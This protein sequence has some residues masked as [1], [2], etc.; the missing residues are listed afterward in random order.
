MTHYSH[1][2]INGEEDW[3]EPN[4]PRFMRIRCKGIGDHMYSPSPL[5]LRSGRHSG[6]W[7]HMGLYVGWIGKVVYVY[8]W[9]VYTKKKGENNPDRLT[10]IT[11]I[12]GGGGMHK[13]EDSWDI[14][15]IYACGKGS[16]ILL[17]SYGGV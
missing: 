12:Y 6:V 14:A 16:Y 9:G 1:D 2:C 5:L 3:G 15:C 17:F 4:I 13:S 11:C 10:R 7:S 8:P